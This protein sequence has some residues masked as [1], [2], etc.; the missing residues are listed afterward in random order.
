MDL[1]TCEVRFTEDESRQSPGRMTGTLLTYEVRAKDRPELFKR[2]ALTWGD[3]G[4]VINEMHDRQRPILR[5]LP[6]LDG[7]SLKIDQ[8]IPD[9]QRGRD[10][11]TNIREGVFTGLSVEFHALQ[12]VRRAGVRE[13]SKGYLSAGGLV[14]VPSYSDSLVDVREKSS[15]PYWK[16]NREMLRWL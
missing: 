3:K 13:I 7:D 11:A 10:A 16:L 12:E 8:K 9:T 14:D 6:F 1:L 15:G 2:S 4:I 5:A